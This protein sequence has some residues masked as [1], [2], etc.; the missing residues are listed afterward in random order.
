MLGEVINLICLM[1]KMRFLELACANQDFA[2]LQRNEGTDDSRI[3]RNSQSCLEFLL[4]CVSCEYHTIFSSHPTT[5]G[6]LAI[7]L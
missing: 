4:L 2:S 3:A 6:L 7:V 1:Q 5:S